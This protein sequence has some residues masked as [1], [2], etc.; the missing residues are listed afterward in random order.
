[1]KKKKDGTREW[2]EPR[3][4][5]TYEAYQQRF[6]EWLQSQPDSE[7]GSSTQVSLN[8]IAS[9][10]TEEAYQQRFEEWLQSQPDSEDGSSTQVSLNDIASIWTQ[11]VSGAKKGRTY[12]LRS[13]YSVCHST[14]LLS[15][16]ASYSQDQEKV[17]A[18]RKEVEELKEERK[19]DR[20]N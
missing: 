13:Q 2:V 20:A 18:L 7:D 11:V 16:D 3:A 19:E 1:M 6:E 12:G 4:A 15:G 17:E 5:R 9:I 8:D 14:T 10:W